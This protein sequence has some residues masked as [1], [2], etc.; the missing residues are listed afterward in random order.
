M[1]TFPEYYVVLLCQSVT[2]AEPLVNPLQTRP[3]TGAYVLNKGQTGT[4][5]CCKRTASEMAAVF[6]VP[7]LLLKQ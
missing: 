6:R 2:R 7:M 4:V 5:P 1:L 3:L